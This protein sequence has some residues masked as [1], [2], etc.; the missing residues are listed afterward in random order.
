MNAQ[1]FIAVISQRH[2]LPRATTGEVVVVD[3][4]CMKEA[5]RASGL[6][7]PTSNA[8]LLA[9]WDGTVVLIALGVYSCVG[10]HWQSSRRTPC[11]REQASSRRPERHSCHTARASDPRTTTLRYRLRSS[12][13][14][15][16][17]AAA[18][19]RTRNSGRRRK[20]CSPEL[21]A[22]RLAGRVVA[23]AGGL[24]SKALALL[25]YESVR[26]QLPPSPDQPA[27]SLQLS[28]ED[29]LHDSLGAGA[30]AVESGLVERGSEGPP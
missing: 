21:H 14:A 25:L 17:G 15:S 26:S 30:E 27:F 9:D 28:D 2:R 5:S 24:Q 19:S 3:P 23:R 13:S 6:A 8:R 18:R 12:G 16:S 7:C 20:R 22:P 10:R 4:L 11:P 29:F 1:G